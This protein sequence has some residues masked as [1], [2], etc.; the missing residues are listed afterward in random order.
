MSKTKVGI[1]FILLIVT[2]LVAVRI[3]SGEDSWICQ[4][5]G[6][7]RHGNPTIPKPLS[8]CN[9]DEGLDIDK[10]LM[11]MIKVEYP[12][13]NQAITSPVTIIGKARGNWYF[14]ASFPVVI[15]DWDGLI[16]AQGHAQANGDWMTTDFV[17]FTATLEFKKPIYKNN[18][19]LILKRDNPSGLPQNDAALEIPIMFK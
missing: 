15:T 14:E 11:D 16:I 1:I 19:T 13:A 10:R 12:I 5:G 8:L 3:L 2:I 9:L 17:P 18:G 4:S 7:V 6:W